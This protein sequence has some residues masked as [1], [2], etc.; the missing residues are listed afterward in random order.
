MRTR[1]LIAAL[2][3]CSTLLLAQTP[4]PGYTDTPMLPGLPYRLHDPARPLPRGVTPVRKTGQRPFGV[5]EL[6][7]G[8]GPGSSARRAGRTDGAPRDRRP[9]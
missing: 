4:N 2:L 1:F 5:Y 8:R 7:L 9:C 3:G 6:V